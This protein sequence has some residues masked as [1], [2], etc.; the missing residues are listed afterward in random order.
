[1]PDKIN[2]SFSRDDLLRYAQE[3]LYLNSLELER[4][5]TVFLMQ[6]LKLQINRVVNIHSIIEE[7]KVLEGISSKSF[8]KKAESFKREPLKGLYK[9]HFFNARFLLRNI[10]SHYGIDFGGNK[11]L[12]EVIKESFTKADAANHFAHNYIVGAYESR[13]RQSKVTGEWIVFQKFEGKNYYLTL[14]AHT[15]EDDLIYE[16]VKMSYEMD[17][18]FLNKNP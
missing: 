2:V 9:K 13:V 17:F 15:E 18:N 5:S 6:T 10:N 12:D 3:Y 14:A 11:F 7:I 16:R 4:V 8:T 1:M